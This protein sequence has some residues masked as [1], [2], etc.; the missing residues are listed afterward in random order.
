MKKD[1]FIENLNKKLEHL[2]SLTSEEL[3]HLY[4]ENEISKRAY[5]RKYRQEMFKK[6]NITSENVFR[7]ELS[8]KDIIFDE[9]IG[10]DNL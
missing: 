10:Q 5:A 6:L 1:S 7:K 3:K 4:I 2:S 8:S 9:I